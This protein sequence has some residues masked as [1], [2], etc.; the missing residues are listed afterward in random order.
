[1]A[2]K[3]LAIDGNSLVHRAYWAL[4]TT[5]MDKEKRHTN[6]V[7]GFFTML[8]RI[9]EEYEPT[10]V[11]VAFDMKEETF[12]HEVFKEYKAGRRKTPDELNEQFPMLKDALTLAGVHYTEQETFEAD[13]ILGALAKEASARSMESYIFT[14]DRDELQLIDEHVSVVLTKKGVSETKL[15]TREAL[16]EEMGITPEQITD[17]KGLMGDASDN[18]PGIAGVGEKTAL[19]LLLEYGTVENLYEHIEELPKNKLY[20]KLVNGKESAFLSKQLATIHR[21]MPLKAT[22]DEFAFDGFDMD[23]LRAMSE[24][25]SFGSFLKRF[26]MEAEEQKKEI[27][28]KTVGLDDLGVLADAVELALYFKGGLHFAVDE[29]NEYLIPQKETLLDEGYDLAEILKAALPLLAGKSIV[30]HDIKGMEHFC[31]D[32]RLT[33]G[34]YFD[35]MLAAWVLNPSHTKYDMESVLE[36]EDIPVG[37]TGLFA[38][39]QRQRE[40]IEEKELDKVYYDIELPLLKVLYDMEKTGVL[41]SD[42]ALKTLG[43]KYEA[44]IGEL[45]ARIYEQ[46]N[47][48]FNISSTKQ[49]AE[50]LFEKLGLPVVKKTKTGYST[51]V[52][53]LE[54]LEDKHPIIPYIMEY[55]TLTKLKG[56]YV[57][58]LRVLIRDGMIH[59]TFLQTVAATGRLS[60]VEPN[61]QNIPIK[62]AMANDIR[63]AFPAPEGYTIVSADYSQIELRILADIADDGHLKDAFLKGQDIHART[64]AEI[65]DKNI[66]DVTK[67]ERASAKA[68]NFGIVYGISDFGLARNLGIT[69][70]KASDYI[71]RYFEEFRGVRRYMDEIIAQAHRDGFVRTLY[72]RIRYIPELASGNFNIRSFGERA[73]LNTP[74]QGSA[75]DIIKIAMNGVADALKKGKFESKLVLQV[76]DEL[77][78]YAK[79]DEADK[80]TK[81]LADCMEHAMKLS[82]PLVVNVAKGKTWA[83]AK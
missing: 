59:T 67:Q 69:R 34:T 13:D 1:M 5:M 40:E 68:V 4:P 20:E 43:E 10:Y 77:I 46:A 35:T 30:A 6:A 16:M 56:T 79:N 3:L 64:A 76:H 38:L 53:V 33:D 14:G 42:E 82:V 27:E 55:R 81:L 45:T 25:Y 36:R 75:A 54:K 51:D 23:G 66:E 74:I 83:E 70:K 19:K 22:L 8:F 48:E 49:L 71:A 7:Y 47:M 32:G 78:L 63:S 80:V 2:D 21:D 37:A 50:V 26:S 57:D 17:L 62:S 61:L 41:V 31:G 60:S 29:E 12:R 39:A 72:G 24:K 58:G 73:A 44:Q 15:M 11:A 9:V 52:E 18:I 65:L 28:I